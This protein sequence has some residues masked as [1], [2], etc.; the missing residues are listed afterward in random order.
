MIDLM[1]LNAASREAFTTRLGPVFE[2]SRWVAEAVWSRRPF[3]TIENLHAAMMA[4][5]LGQDEASI[6]AFLNAHPDLAGREAKQGTMTAESVEEQGTAGLDRLSASEVTEMDELNRKY[7]AR[8]GFPFIVCVR[9]YTK[10]G[11]FAEFRHRIARRSD[12]ERREA[13]RQIGFISR[14]RLDA[15]FHREA[16]QAVAPAA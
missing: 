4:V 9:H 1:S 14:Y 15:L 13:L 8:H 6:A 16:M 2:N 12:D 5:V 11:I 3:D 10:V 7:R